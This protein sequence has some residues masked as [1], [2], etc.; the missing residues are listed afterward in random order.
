MSSED[1]EIHLI[2][3]DEASDV[4]QSIGSNLST[5]FTDVEGNTQGLVTTTD[6]ATNQIVY[7]YSQVSDAGQQLQNSQADLQMSTSDTVMSMNNL[8]LGGAALAMSFMNVENRQVAVDRANLM[9]ERGLATLQKAQDSYNVA[10]EKYGADSSQA[11]AAADKLSIAQDAYNVAVERADMSQRNL[12]MSMTMAALTVIP[13]LVSMITIVSKSTEIWEGIQ[14]ALNTV[15]DVNPIFLVITAIGALVAALALIPG[16]WDAV[17]NAFRAA[18]NFIITVANDIGNAWNGFV[19]LFTGGN[20]Q[21]T[22]SVN[23]LT[24]AVQDEGDKLISASQNIKDF[25]T[26]LDAANASVWGV[27]EVLWRNTTTLGEYQAKAADA[28]DEVKVLDD[29]IAS[30]TDSYKKSKDELDKDIAGLEAQKIILESV[31]GNTKEVQGA[32]EKLNAKEADMKKQLD[33]TTTSL[34]S[35]KAAVEAAQKAAQD[36]ATFIENLTTE[37]DE[38]KAAVDTNLGA[39]KAAFDDAFN[40]GDFNKALGIVQD[41][42]NKYGLS[43]SDAE[44]T[45]DA[46]KAAQAAVPQT[47]EEQLIGKAQA[48]LQT[49]QNCATGKFVNLE[50]DTS[51]SMEQV[52]SD[53]NDLISR[54][55]VGQAQDSIQTFVNCATSKHDTLVSNIE[56][57]LAKLRA[58]Y[59]AGAADVAPYIKSLEE[60]K[61]AATFDTSGA[62]ILD[63]I[64]LAGETADQVAAQTDAPTTQITGSFHD[65][66]NDATT[67]LRMLQ[68][69]IV[70][71]SIWTDML[72]QMEDTTAKSVAKIQAQFKTLQA[73]GIVGGGGFGVPE[74]LPGP[75]GNAPNIFHIG[76]LVHID[77]SADKAT[78]DLATRQVLDKLKSIVV[79][80]TTSFASTTQ[81]R[82]RQGAVTY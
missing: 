69:N 15:M 3:Y 29:Q 77:G 40:A 67:T 16:A 60:F 78:V 12:S 20:K 13:S 34:G 11:Q 70:G 42:A 1:V 9:V 75:S 30:L 72:T 6:N 19:G 79:E 71:G 8:A 2:A 46:F 53:T 81:K 25:Q 48:D 22:D 35:Q 76:E 24:A 45:I 44:K 43:L 52:V 14:A 49:F 36:D 64:K 31:G 56:S 39:V 38:M 7:D 37:Y 51:A 82:I 26:Q 80:P 50:T 27:D 58:A 32:I 66:A 10:V 59:A 47:I 33:D 57:D 4:I 68:H 21:A 41:F 23:G 17:V 54:G 28:S 61:L 18:G 65:I 63:A 55:L 74:A 62:T 73:E 5:T